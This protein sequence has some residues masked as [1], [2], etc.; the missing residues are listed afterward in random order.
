MARAR[1]QTHAGHTEYTSIP[2]VTIILCGGGPLILPQ[3]I[4]S[5]VTAPR[6]SPRGLWI[7]TREGLS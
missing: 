7:E 5:I 2:F 3:Q 1:T 6:G 4:G